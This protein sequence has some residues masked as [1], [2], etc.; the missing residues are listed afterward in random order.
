MGLKVTYGTLKRVDKEWVLSGIPPHVSLRLKSMFPKVSKA[1]I[2]EF[3]FRLNSENCADLEWFL[4]R[5]PMSMSDEDRALLS[6]GT[7]S[8]VRSRDEIETI[9]LPDWKPPER[10]GFKPGFAPYHMQAQAI[11]IAHRKKQLLVCDDVGLGKTIVALGT[12]AAS[13]YLPAAIVCPTH[14][15]IQWVNEYIKPFTYMSAH[16]IRGTRPYSLPPANIYLFKPSNIAGWVDVAATGVF[17]SVIFDEIQEFRHGRSTEKGIAAHVFRDHTRLRMGLSATPI[18][19]Y[20]S[21]IFNIVELI[22]P[23]ALGTWEEFTREWC[24]PRKDKWVVKDPDGL[25]TYLRELQVLIRRNR[26]G[27]LI[28]TIMIEVVADKEI[29]QKS[30]DLARTLASKVMTGSFTESGQAARELDMLARL[31]TGLS[32]AKSVAAYASMF[33]KTGKPII[34]GA[35]HREVYAVLMKELAP[36]KPVMFTGSESPRQKERAKQ[37]FIKGETDCVLMSLRSG[38][39]VDGLQKRCSTVM[40]AEFDWSKQVHE[41]LI[42]R[43]DRPGQ[44]EDVIDQIVCW[45]NSGSDPPIMDVIGLK[46]DQSRGILDPMSGVVPVYRDESRMKKLAEHYLSRAS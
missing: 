30:I 18:Y 6:R 19:G 46:A 37:A 23:G 14:L 42:G 8:F 22:A 27:R 4:Q 9:M 33:L 16:I 11:E 43:V 26:Q 40:L 25:G 17:R 21:E 38:L 7:A 24:T 13:P 36:H 3:S 34:I 41:Q 45:T 10:C 32:K 1:T 39:G 12:I 15:P 20:G 29:E 44:T 35:W 2:G 5:Y 31:V 28:N